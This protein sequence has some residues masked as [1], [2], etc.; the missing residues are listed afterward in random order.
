MVARSGPVE[1]TAST[2]VSTVV[3]E[4][5]VLTASQLAWLVELAQLK[6]PNGECSNCLLNEGAMFRAACQAAP[7]GT[8]AVHVGTKAVH[9]A[10]V[11]SVSMA[12]RKSAGLRQ[13]TQ[14]AN[15]DEDHDTMQRS[16]AEC[17]LSRR[18]EA[19]PG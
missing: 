17:R 6:A 4:V 13:L 5:V 19:E 3:A 1:S 2:R 9:T 16:A 11:H 15:E 8:K 12:M 18:E 14:H 10:C 7:A